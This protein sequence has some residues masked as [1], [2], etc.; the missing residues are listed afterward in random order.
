MSSFDWIVIGA[1]ITGSALSY[2]LVKAGFRVLLIDRNP[3][4]HNATY[5]SYGGIA[6]WAGTTDLTRSLCEEG[7]AIHRQLS[8]ELDSDTE[9]REID[10]LLT[11]APDADLETTIN[12]HQ[13]FAQT[14]E[15]LSPQAACELE[16]QLNPAGFQAALKF[17]HAHANA[18]AAA[19]AYQKQFQNLGGVYQIAEVQQ[20]LP[21]QVVTSAGIFLSSQIALCAGSETRSLLSMKAIAPHFSHAES[22]VTGPVDFQLRTLVMPAVTERFVLEAEAGD[23]KHDDLWDSQGN[24]PVVP[25]LD[26]G[27]IQFNNGHLR[28][29]QISRVK[30]GLQDQV[31]AVVSEQTLRQAIAPILPNIAALPGQWQSCTV[32]FSRDHLPI[33]GSLS[34]GQGPTGG[35]RPDLHI[36]SGFSNPM[37][38]VPA[39]ARRFAQDF[40]HP[41][42]LLKQLSP[43][44]FL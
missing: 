29:G 40:A 44:R 31:D 10:L 8:A 26:A 32:A 1:G 34:D 5:Q 21:N 7:I 30:T 42:A 11:I 22:I 9:F 14:P 35:H 18:L 13:I 6:Y 39:L 23:P 27:A 19:F 16:P 4:A 33:V 36:F 17:R 24:E 25:I 3:Q 41:D 12:S 37:V 2:E 20:I 38:F 28:M 43:Q 15:L